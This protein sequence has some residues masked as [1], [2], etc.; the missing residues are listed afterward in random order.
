MCGI[1]AYLGSQEAIPFLLEGLSRLEYR[2]YD[3][4]GIA[5]LGNG[6]VQTFKKKGKVVELQNHI[7]N[8]NISASIGI[9]HT[10]W[11]T[12]GQP[13]DINAHPHLS[14]DGTL[15]LIH[16]GIIENYQS[17]KI[18]L[19]EKGYVF[20]SETDTEVVAHLIQEFKNGGK[21][22]TH[23]AFRKALNIIVGAY[24]IVLVDA[25]HPDTLFAARKSSP[26]VFG[27][28]NGEYFLSSDVSPISQYTN[29]FIFLDDEQMIRVHRSGKYLLTDLDNKVVKGT[30]TEMDIKLEE[31]ERMATHTSCLKKSINSQRPFWIVCAV[32]SMLRKG[33]SLLV[34]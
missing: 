28:G 30:I 26:L 32:G 27:I 23:E 31:L 13:D 6:G 21:V 17:L 1:V 33:G 8:Q 34:V 3:S 29:R 2:G 11:A 20:S 18:A 14:M 7:G 10:R 9:G 24:A 22:S 5:V 25:D 19:K 16:N 15:G 4:A 12:H